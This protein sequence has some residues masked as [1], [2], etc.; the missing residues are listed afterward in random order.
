MNWNREPDITHPASN[1]ASAADIPTRDRND[2]KLVKLDIEALSEMQLRFLD[3]FRQTGTIAAAT[4]LANVHRATVH[5]WKAQPLFAAVMDAFLDLF[6]IELIKKCREAE[7][8]RQAWREQRERE[9][10]PMRCRNLAL[11]R[12]ARREKRGY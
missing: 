9:R 5:R 12:D 4:R 7:A 8:V 10:R 6:H 1:P 11:A 3:A 2:E